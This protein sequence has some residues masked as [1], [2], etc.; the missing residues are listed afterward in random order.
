MP[1]TDVELNSLRQS[2]PELKLRHNAAWPQLTTWGV[3]SGVVPVVAE[4]GDVQ[5]LS[6]LI[7]WCT[8]RH[9]RWFL[10]GGGANVCGMDEPFDGIVVRLYGGEF[11]QMTLLSG[12]RISCAAGVRLAE[13]AV[14]A[15]QNNLGGITH[16][17]AIPGS[18]GG[19]LRMNAGAEQR[20]IGDF[21][22]EMSGIFPDGTAWKMSKNEMTW[23]YRHSPMPENGIITAAVFE[24]PPLNAAAAKQEFA[25]FAAARRRREPKGRSAGCVFR[26]PAGNS[27]GKLIDEAGLK[28]KRIGAAEVSMAHG[29]FILNQGAATEVEVTALMSDI[30]KNIAEKF[31]VK[32]V[33]EVV[34]ANPKNLDKIM[35]NVMG[36]QVLVL[37]GGVSSEREV[38]L[39]SGR[40][41]AEA[42]IKGGYNVTTEDVKECK[43]SDAMR[44]AEVIFPVLHGG[45]GED[46]TLQKLL[47]QAGKKFVGCGS[48]SSCIVMD[49]IATKR[50]FDACRIPTAKWAVVTPEKREFPLGLQLPVVVKAPREGSS[51]GIKQVLEMT[52]W[53]TV[54]DELFSL[55]DEL[56]VE[57]FVHG[58]EISVPVINGIILPPVEIRPPHGFY[59]YDAKYVYSAGHT[60]Y[61]CPAVSLSPEVLEHAGRLAWKFYDQVG[62]KEMLRVDFIVD[63]NGIPQAL[64]GNSLPGFTA[65][66][67]VPKSAGVFGFSFERLCSELL[68][69]ALR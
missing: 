38:S 47:E 26:N 37:M 40:A 51:V 23:S 64:E 15:A 63:K 16:L 19:A 46:G 10:L 28:G 12:N 4:P 18:V 8:N 61:F 55:S 60:E 50:V 7:R 67:L 30:H 32:L 20:S 36:A 65:T 69:A 35:N 22:V 17:S 54:L 44:R 24:F 56:L 25:D 62:A 31:A 11:R 5:E 68:Q 3:G 33:P 13:L 14:F 43:I 34:F 49:K 58:V 27:A 2:L 57:E 39:R 6:T 42:L 66:S 29:N 53:N 52:E 59:D 48:V 21:T 41:V 9:C 1:I 45:F